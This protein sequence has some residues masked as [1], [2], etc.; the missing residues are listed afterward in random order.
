MTV[1]VLYLRKVREVKAVHRPLENDYV[2]YGFS[3]RHVQSL[4]S[5]SMKSE[6][7]MI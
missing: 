5:L 1:C 7:G 4:S 6:L 2:W 3:V